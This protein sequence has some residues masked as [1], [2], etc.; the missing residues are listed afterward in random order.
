MATPLAIMGRGGH[1]RGYGKKLPRVG[2]PSRKNF[3]SIKNVR[4]LI[5]S[6]NTILACA[7]NQW[8]RRH[9]DAPTLH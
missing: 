1:P 9:S 8:H 4:A 2:P 7:D 6:F 3:A 5:A